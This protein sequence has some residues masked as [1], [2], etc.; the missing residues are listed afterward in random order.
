M[1]DISNTKADFESN[2]A[3]NPQ[4]SVLLHTQLTHRKV[5]ENSAI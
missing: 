1:F 5:I 4:K 2:N 3:S